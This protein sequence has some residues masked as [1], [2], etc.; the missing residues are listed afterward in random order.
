MPKKHLTSDVALLH[1]RW[2][3]F[4]PPRFGAATAG[5]TYGPTEEGGEE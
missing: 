2:P 5:E 4:S 3:A 1:H